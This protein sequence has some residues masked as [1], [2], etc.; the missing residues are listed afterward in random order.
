[1]PVNLTVLVC[2]VRVEATP[3]LVLGWW[4]YL[5]YSKFQTQ[6]EP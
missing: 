3:C 6:Q 4:G 5:F 2:K 1:V